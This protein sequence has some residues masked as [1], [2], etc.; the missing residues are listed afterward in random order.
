MSNEREILARLTRK[1]ARES[2]LGARATLACAI[3]ELDV[4]L[5][6]FESAEDDGGR[7]RVMNWV[8]NHLVC[9]IQ[10]N[11]RIDRLAD[12]QAELTRLAG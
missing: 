6:K 4:Y 10:G 12:H 1:Q 5:D 2:L 11:L 7:A 8:I 9:N 3:K